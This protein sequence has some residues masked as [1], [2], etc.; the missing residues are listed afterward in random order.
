MATAAPTTPPVS[1]ARTR[2]LVFLSFVVVMGL[3]FVCL[4]SIRRDAVSVHKLHMR[5]RREQIE[6]GRAKDDLEKQTAKLRG[7]SSI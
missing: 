4:C 3:L 1:Y 2:E 5:K 7:K 6:T